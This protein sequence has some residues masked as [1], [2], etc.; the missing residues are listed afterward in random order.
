LFKGL[1]RHGA[2]VAGP[3]E[4]YRNHPGLI[5]IDKLNIPP[6]GLER[7]ANIVDGAENFLIHF[8]LLTSINL[9]DLIGIV[10]NESFFSPKT[11][12]IR[13]LRGQTRQNNKKGPK[14][15]RAEERVTENI[16]FCLILSPFF[17]LIGNIG[18]FLNLMIK[19]NRDRE[20]TA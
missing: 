2:A 8:C 19:E 18:G 6:I 10:K 11:P 5:D 13:L 15:G 16:G 12:K 17:P 14:T 9:S 7:R 20:K 1:L 4:L 3:G